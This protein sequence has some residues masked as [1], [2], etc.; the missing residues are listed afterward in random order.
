MPELQNPIAN[1]RIKKYHHFALAAAYIDTMRASK[2]AP[3]AMVQGSDNHIWVVCA[4]D[5]ARLIDAGYASIDV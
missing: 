3:F 2:G 4:D 5:Y 1:D